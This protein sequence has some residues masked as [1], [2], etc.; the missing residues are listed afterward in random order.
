MDADRPRRTPTPLPSSPTEV[1]M[2]VINTD[3]VDGDERPDFVREALSGTLV[4]LELHWP[5]ELRHVRAH[6]YVATLGE[7]TICSGRT[8]AL[9]VDRTP[10][11]TRDDTVEPSIFVHVQHSGSSLVVQHGREAL[12]RP[13]DLVIYDAAAPYTL[14]NDRGV[15][16]DFFQIPHSA[17][18]LSEDVIRG[19]CAVNLADGHP[20]ASL[21]NSYLRSLAAET[22]LMTQRD[23]DLAGRPTIELV[24]AAIITHL[25]GGD[26]A[27]APTSA[28]GLVQCVLEY[29]RRHLDD[30]ELSARQIAA[31]NYISVRHL[32][33]VLAE[34]GIGLADWIRTRRLEACRHGLAE[35]H[36]TTT[37][38]AIARGHG[39]VDMSSFS[40]AFRSEYGMTPREWREQHSR[41]TT[42]SRPPRS[43]KEQS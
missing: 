16:G 4:P 6:G 34:R 37:I 43:T 30:P 39:F 2:L 23:A 14:V 33:K 1:D 26:G 19:A 25:G 42:S 20:I 18:A 35:A 32:Y 5:D 31:A 7:L 21:T 38:A 36:P 41:P 27:P 3:D 13:G 11:L 15:T 8:T 22:S 10:R 17:L 9:R 29:A 40:R 24:R 12:S 28:A